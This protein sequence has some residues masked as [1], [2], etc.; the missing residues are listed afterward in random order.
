MPAYAT[1]ESWFYLEWRSQELGSTCNP[2]GLR[3]RVLRCRCQTAEQLT[4]AAATLSDAPVFSLDAAKHLC[5]KSRH[6]G[7]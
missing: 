6:V 7:P 1:T 2:G 3:F 5:L 4:L